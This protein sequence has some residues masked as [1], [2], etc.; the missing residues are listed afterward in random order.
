M[1]CARCCA[2]PCPTR[3]SPSPARSRR[4]PRSSTRASPSPALATSPSWG[5][6]ACRSASSPTR[7][8][9][10]SMPTWRSTPVPRPTSRSR[11]SAGSG[12]LV[13]YPVGGGAFTSGGTI[14][15]LTALA[16]ARE[17]ALPG[18]RAE[19]MGGL[20]AA[21]YCSAEAHYSVMRAAELLGIGAANVRPIGLDGDRRMVP[22]ELAE[23][24][25][26]DR[27]AGVTPV[28]VI[29]TAGTT[30]TG[31]VDPIARLADSLPGARG[32]AAR[33]RRLRTGGRL[34]ARDRRPVRGP[35]PGRL[36]IARRPQVAL[37]AE[38]LR[39]DPGAQARGSAPLVR[40]RRG[41]P[42]ARARR[43]ARRRRHARV[44]APVPRAEAV[45]G[46]PCARR[47]GLP[48]RGAAQ[49]APGGTAPRAGHRSAGSGGAGRR[50]SS[51][52]CRSGT[53]PP[54]SPTW[55]RTTR[56]CPSSCSTTPASTSPRPRST[57][58]CTCG[59]CIVNFRTSD[60]D[61]AAL[62]EIAREVGEVVAE[63]G[64]G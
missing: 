63:A 23:A 39:R 7:W 58:A 46:L 11:P 31:A 41:L 2:S 5:R 28:A 6:P 35:R 32:V 9:P 10:A 8:P 17:R 37:P 61:V 54:A 22:D 55:T 14:S 45:A 18:A 30:L 64:D 49:P 24:L 57:A 60:A 19:G 1:I 36:G 34:P 29:A 15:N 40:A 62:V 48:P 3:L 52:S 43:A 56:G 27:A 12:E 13:G 59:P 38:G 4:P 53:F 16:A 44:L 51:R 33:G 21:V 50:R 42:A 20:R 25:D 47:G 26:R